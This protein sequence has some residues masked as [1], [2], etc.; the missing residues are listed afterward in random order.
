M[1]YLGGADMKHLLLMAAVTIPILILIAKA[2]TYRW[3]RILMF[4][5]PFSSDIE[6]AYQLRQALYALGSGGL[7]GKGLN[8]STQKL[9]FLP[10]GESDMIYAIIGEELGFVGCT[11]LICA[12]IFVVYR[13]IRIA[14]KCKDR[15]GSLLAAGITCVLGV[16]AAVN[17]AVATSSVPPTR[18][19]LPFVSLGGTSLMIFLSAMGILLSIS[20]DVE[21][22]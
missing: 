12:Y 17:I 2:E 21:I 14:I 16:Q 18:Q 22:E 4:M 11:A 19:T 15:F 5:D 13:G 3:E 7:F 10:L 20:R 1:L 8:F 6:G 9:L